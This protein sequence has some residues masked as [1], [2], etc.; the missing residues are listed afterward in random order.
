MYNMTKAERAHHDMLKVRANMAAAYHM[1]GK[2]SDEECSAI[3]AEYFAFS[4]S[5][6]KKY[7]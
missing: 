4:C 5:M 3:K 1:A 2:M 7:G 6:R